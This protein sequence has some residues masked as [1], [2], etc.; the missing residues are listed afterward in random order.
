MSDEENAGED[1]NETIEKIASVVQVFNTVLSCLRSKSSQRQK[2]RYFH[3][4]Y[5]LVR[6]VYRLDS[7]TLAISLG[8]IHSIPL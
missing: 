1:L 7:K 2:V 6:T 8:L 5:M 4:F 3:N